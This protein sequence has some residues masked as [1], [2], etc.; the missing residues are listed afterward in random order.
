LYFDGIFSYGWNDYD[1]TR[2]IVYTVPSTDRLGNPI[3]GVTTVNQ[4]SR[5]ETDG[6]QYA[7]SFSMG[8]DFTVKGLT[9]GPYSRINYLKADIDAFQERIDNTNPGSGL[10]LAIDE[11]DV[12]SFTWVL[13]GQ[14]SYAVSTGFAVL[15]PQ[16]RFEWEH[17]FLNDRRTVTA[18]LISDPAN[19]PIFLQTDD[20]DHDYFNFGAGVSAVFQHNVAA[21][22]YYE[23]VLAL[24]DVTAHK[25]AAG[26]R[27][28]F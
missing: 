27:L 12:E 24:R 19:T 28:A 20:P 7:F 1:S 4:T 16:M 11:Q 6:S 23:T 8:Y 14:G 2:N 5:T 26:V 15:V 17:E 3:P 9:I 10:S 25:I 21:F 13:G 18:T 22:V